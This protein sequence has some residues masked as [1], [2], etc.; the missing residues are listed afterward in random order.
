M[1]E[2]LGDLLRD[3]GHL[4]HN[5]VGYYSGPPL[6]HVKQLHGNRSRRCIRSLHKTSGFLGLQEFIPWEY[7]VFKKYEHLYDI[8]HVHDII[9]TASPITIRLMQ[10]KTPVVITLHDCS[11]ITGGCIQPLDCKSYPKCGKFCPE[12]GYW[13]MAGKIN[14][15]RLMQRLKKFLWLNSRITFAAP[16][17]W[18]AEQAR[19]RKMTPMPVRHI[20]NCVET[21]IFTPVKNKA[22][23]R[24]QLG[25]PQKVPIAV[26][27]SGSLKDRYKGVAYA[28]QAMH[29]VIP[30]PF[31]LLIGK[32]KA[33]LKHLEGL[34]WKQTGYISDR[35]FLSDFF[36]AADFFVHS[37][38]ADNQPLVTLEALS[39]GL[40]VAAF[41]TGGIPEYI[42]DGFNGFLSK[43]RDAPGLAKKI[44]RLLKNPT[45]LKKM[46]LN[47][48]NYAL[49]TFSPSEFLENHLEL[50]KEL[51]AMGSFQ[52]IA[53]LQL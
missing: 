45:A 9:Q 30:V 6:E 50:Y 28:I 46:G 21:D 34:D 22:S 25:L 42:I 14:C 32:D 18:M 1:A 36:K 16:S 8:I 35:R 44:T 38:L 12:H 13:P 5:W 2:K 11:F 48:R 23:L 37:P 24:Y 52:S 43:T 49:Q 53:G 20:P 4:A 10:Q 51:T 39:S 26:I 31:V 40:P 29:Q 41:A 7:A 33:P 27:S 15:T 3:A 47:S 19:I 17:L